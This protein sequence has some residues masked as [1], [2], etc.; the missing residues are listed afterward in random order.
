MC[1]GL[2]SVINNNSEVKYIEF[3]STASCQLVQV[4]CKVG[5]F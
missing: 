1:S 4:T 5:V 2:E 3:Y